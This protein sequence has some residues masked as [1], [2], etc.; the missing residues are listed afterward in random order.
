ME[1]NKT[2]FAQQRACAGG[3]PSYAV[4]C[5]FFVR[6]ELSR[7]KTPSSVWLLSRICGRVVAREGAF[8]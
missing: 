6:V 8:G 5:F 2:G 3:Q 1:A 4:L 7:F